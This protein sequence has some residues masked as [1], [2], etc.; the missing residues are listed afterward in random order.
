MFDDHWLARWEQGRTGW[1][2]A[3]GNAFLRTYWPRGSR[4]SRVLV[5]LCGKSE[6]MLWLARQGHTVIG[7]ELSAIAVRAFFS[8]YDLGF[9]V[10][11]DGSFDRYT[12]SSLPVTIYCGDYFSLTVPPCEALYDR[13]SLI[14]LPA[15]KRPAYVVHTKQLLTSQSMRLVISVSYDDTVVD[16]PPFS[17][18]DEELLSYWPD[19]EKLDERNDISTAPPKFR[20]AGL[21]TMREAVWLARGREVK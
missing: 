21:D 15:D 16:G 2:E 12:A 11:R 3:A 5:P 4:A 9:S 19:L 7:A 18:C 1:H 10:E 14:A 8:E 17:L 20:E 13:G 6:D